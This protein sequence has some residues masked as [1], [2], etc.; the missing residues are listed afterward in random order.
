MKYKET[1]TAIKWLKIFEKQNLI[2]KVKE[3]SY[4]NGKY[5]QPTT[6]ILIQDK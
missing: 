6:Y 5:R 3:S 4:G 2:K 1:N